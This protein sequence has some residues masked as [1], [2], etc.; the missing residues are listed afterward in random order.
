M[1]N[2]DEVAPTITSAAAATTVSENSGVNQIVY[3]ATAT[4]SVDIS[5]GVSFSLED[6][7]KAAFSIDAATGVV[8]LLGNPDF[9]T[10]STYSFAVLATDKARN[11]SSLPVTLKI[12]NVSEAPT[13]KSSATVTVFENRTSVMT[14][15][16]VDPEAAKVSYRIVGGAD[17]AKFTINAVTGALAFKAA[18]N[19]EAPTD[20]GA[21]NIYQVAV[22]V[23]DGRL[24]SPVQTIAVGV[25]NVNEP[26]VGIAKTITVA[27]NASYTFTASDFGFR[28]PRDKT[29]N[30]LKAVRIASLPTRE[31][32]NKDGVAVKAG[33]LITAADI[34]AGKL[35]FTPVVNTRGVPYASFKFQIQDDG[36]ALNGGVDIDPT[37]KV[38]TIR[39]R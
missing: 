10:K 19:F 6:A 25:L 36:G 4:D 29:P 11:A 20:A 17:A 28:D 2:V 1:A 24:T 5:G 13:I 3:T 32:L 30:A 23:S 9:E 21:N 27:R 35:R 14:V 12:N 33:D 16:G 26:P 37:A 22:R 8:R 18:P 38:M 34:A 15:V 31:S 39:V 7:D